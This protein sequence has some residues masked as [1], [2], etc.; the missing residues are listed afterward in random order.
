[1]GNHYVVAEA[2]KRVTRKYPGGAKFGDFFTETIPTGTCHAAAPDD[3]RTACGIAV[4]PPLVVIEEH[5]WGSGVASWCEQCA[6]IV[7][8]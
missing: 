1:M 8:L 2:A 6:A 5:R 7:P 3:E 4:K